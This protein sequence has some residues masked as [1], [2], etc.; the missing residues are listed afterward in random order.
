MN[1]LDLIQLNLSSPMVLAFVLGIVATLIKSDLRLPEAIYTFASIYLLFAIGLKGGFALAQTSLAEFW[2]PALATLGLGSLIPIWCYVILR[3]LGKF[4]I[5]DAAALAAHFGSVSAV[6][7]SAGLTFVSELNVPYEGFMPT[8]MALMEIPA[9]AVALI[10]AQSRLAVQKIIIP[11]PSG[12]ESYPPLP[13]SQSTGNWQQ[14]L[15]EVLTGKSI[16]LLVGGL[17][18]GLIAGEPGYKQIAP[19]FVDLF[20]GVLTI[21][22]L[23][24]GVTAG[25]CLRDLRRAGLFLVGFSTVMPVIH[26]CIGVLVGDLSGLSLGGSMLLGLLAASASYIAAPAAVRIALPQANP[27]YYLTAAIAIA[28][29]FNL[30]IGLPLYFAI[31]R[32]LQ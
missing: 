26:G 29:P 3:R 31:A 10:I 30:T 21:F 18:I 16:V 11:S 4:G 25:R 20:P 12:Q 9:I 8:L 2:L 22:L 24:L 28:F 32:F 7:F 13:E 5:A 19:F 15:H 23:E 17:L 14:A 27:C 1:M 6:T